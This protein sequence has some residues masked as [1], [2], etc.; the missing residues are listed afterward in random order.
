MFVGIDIQ[1]LRASWLGLLPIG[2]WACGFTVISLWGKA[3]KPRLKRIMLW[4]FPCF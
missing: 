2:L 3:E 4:V 1:V